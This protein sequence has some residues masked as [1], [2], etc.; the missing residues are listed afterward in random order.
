MYYPP[1]LSND[2]RANPPL[3]NEI[4]EKPRFYSN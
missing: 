1:P 2:E 3:D 4:I